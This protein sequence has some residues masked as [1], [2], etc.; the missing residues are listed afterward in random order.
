MLTKEARLLQG[1]KDPRVHSHEATE[2]LVY[3]SAPKLCMDFCSSAEKR[4]RFCHQCHRG[5]SRLTVHRQLNP[6]RR[7]TSCEVDVKQVQVVSSPY[8]ILSLDSHQHLV[9]MN[10]NS[11]FFC[12]RVSG[13]QKTRCCFLG[14]FVL[15]DW[16]HLQEHAM[17]AAHPADIV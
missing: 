17:L 3:A 15:M 12:R 9:R 14:A 7:V 8:G 11:R 1:H 13:E 10:I 6:L 5:P 2:S 16:H 4:R